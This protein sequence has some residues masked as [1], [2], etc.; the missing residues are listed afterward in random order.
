MKIHLYQIDAQYARVVTKKKAFEFSE[1]KHFDLVVINP[2][3]ILV[4]VEREEGGRERGRR[5]GGRGEMEE[6]RGRGEEGSRESVLENMHLVRQN[7]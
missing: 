1:G 2:N 4:F 6:G 5:G 3:G 7:I